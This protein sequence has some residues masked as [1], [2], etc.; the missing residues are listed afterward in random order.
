MACASMRGPEIQERVA[1]L[2]LSKPIEFEG[3]KSLIIDLFPD[4]EISTVLLTEHAI[5]CSWVITPIRGDSQ[6]TA[7]FRQTSPPRRA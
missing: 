2:E 7:Y 3:F 4:P 1:T 6:G 5:A